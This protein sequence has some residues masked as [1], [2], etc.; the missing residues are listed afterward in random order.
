MNNKDNIKSCVNYNPRP[1]WER[2]TGSNKCPMCGG[3]D[4][5]YNTQIILTSYPPQSQLRCKSCGHYFSSGIKTEWTDNDT[6]NKLWE[7]D[8]SILH[9]PYIG[10]PPPGT[11]P[12][13]GDWP[14][15]PTP[16]DPLPATD[17]TTMYG[18]ICPK[19]GKVNAPHRDFCDCSGGGYY[20]N[21]VYCGGTG[22]NPN[23]APTIT[24]SEADMQTCG[25][26]NTRYT[27]KEN[28][29]G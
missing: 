5:E 10:D 22:N 20:P 21:I 1:E 11:I 18:W 17:K 23:P 25:Y 13:I 19:C 6:L 27:N 7:Q 14:P 26:L 8:Q 28:K 16:C 9:G 24:T 15:A 3:D 29:N 2:W 12:H 4:I